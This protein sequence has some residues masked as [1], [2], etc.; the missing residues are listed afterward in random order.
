MCLYRSKYYFIVNCIWVKAIKLKQSPVCINLNEYWF[1]DRSIL[2][3]N[4]KVLWKQSINSYSIL[5]LSLPTERRQRYHSEGSGTDAVQAAESEDPS[6]PSQPLPDLVNT[7]FRPRANTE[8]ARPRP[9]I[10]VGEQLR[11]ISDEFH[12]SYEEVRVS[13]SIIC[14]IS[15]IIGF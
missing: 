1:S 13:I 3:S 12:F 15:A 7:A 5:L 9:E 11:R 10:Q 8:P 14:H 6:N 4:L 2:A